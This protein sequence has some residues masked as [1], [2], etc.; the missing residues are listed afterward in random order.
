MASPFPAPPL[1]LSHLLRR[2]AEA[3]EARA[4]D[5]ANVLTE[6]GLVASDIW[7]NE[8]EDGGPAGYCVYV[9]PACAGQ[10]ELIATAFDAEHGSALD[11]LAARGVEPTRPVRAGCGLF[12]FFPVILILMG[13]ATFVWPETGSRAAGAAML[14]GGL[15]MIAASWWIAAQDLSDPDDV[16]R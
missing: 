10:A 7:V 4:G 13:A 12:W 8:P 16:E 14:A 2:Y 9:E 15:L 3:D 11:Y 1:D 6:Q 5:L